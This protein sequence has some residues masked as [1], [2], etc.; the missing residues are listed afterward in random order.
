[1]STDP[2]WD[3]SPRLKENCPLPYPRAYT[4]ALVLPMMKTDSPR[5]MKSRRL[6]IALGMSLSEFTGSSCAGLNGGSLT[7]LTSFLC[8]MGFADTNL[9]ERSTMVCGQR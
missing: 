1:M 9:P 2:D 8:C 5:S 6:A 3:L 7:P 4:S